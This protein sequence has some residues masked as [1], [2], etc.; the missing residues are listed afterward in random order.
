MSLFDRVV[1]VSEI[2]GID[3]TCTRSETGDRQTERERERVRGKTG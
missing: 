3:K 2:I 1:D